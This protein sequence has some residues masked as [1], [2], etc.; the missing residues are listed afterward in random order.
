M[1]LQSGRRYYPSLQMLRGLAALAVVLYHLGTYCAQTKFFGIAGMAVPFAFGHAGVQFFFVL[2][3][4]IIARVHRADIG[5]PR[6][7]GGYLARRF[8]RIYPTYWL[9]FGI[10]YAGALALGTASDTLPQNGWLLLKSLLLLPQDPAEVGGTGAPVVWVAWTLQ[11]EIY[12]YAWAA[13]AIAGPRWLVTVIVAVLLYVAW[14]LEKGDF[15]AGFLS[16]G[17]IGMFLAG[18][19]SAWLADKLSLSLTGARAVFA[20]GVLVFVTS[21]GAEI[22]RAMNGTGLDLVWGYALGA[23]L[24][25]FGAVK[26]E[27]TAGQRAMGVP[28]LLRR[29]GDASYS[30]YLIHQPLLGICFKFVL[31]LGA[32]GLAGAALASG[33]GLTVGIGAGYAIHRWFERPV[34]DRSAAWLKAR[35]WA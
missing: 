15:V 21:A 16:S 9:V 30:I 33:L 5:R 11:Y 12:F 4:F 34:L 31:A 24:M 10:V 8:L 18:A 35:A 14:G 25:V 7:L 1:Q 20:L 29:L 22:W 23:V 3:G 28:R 19:F 26:W 13:L 27:D 32:T 17:F 6:R 2:S